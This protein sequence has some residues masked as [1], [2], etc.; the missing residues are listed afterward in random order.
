MWSVVP[1]NRPFCY[2]YCCTVHFV[3]SLQLSHQLMHLHKFHIKTFKIAPMILRSK[4][5]GAIL[6]VIMWNLCKCVSW[7]DNWRAHFALTIPLQASFYRKLT[8][9]AKITEETLLPVRQEH[10]RGSQG[11]RKCKNLRKA[12]KQNSLDTYVLSSVNIYAVWL[13]A[14]NWRQR[15]ATSAQIW[16]KQ[17]DSNYD[18]NCT[19]RHCLS[20]KYEIS[21]RWIFVRRSVPVGFG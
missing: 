15:N 14:M 9:G 11:G 20:G 16:G 19:A 7:C 12:T 2:L 21:G 5:V 18:G 13:I 1:K 17:N 10:V 3:E 6:N 8:D 4:H